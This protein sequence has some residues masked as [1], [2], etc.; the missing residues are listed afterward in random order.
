MHQRVAA[1]QD[2]GVLFLTSPLPLGRY[3]H[4]RQYRHAERELI[5]AFKEAT[6]STLAR[7]ILDRAMNAAEADNCYQVL[8]PVRR[9]IR[10]EDATLGRSPIRKGAA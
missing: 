7:E 2:D 9:I 3:P 10:H 6:T 8:S 4:K 5:A 1:A